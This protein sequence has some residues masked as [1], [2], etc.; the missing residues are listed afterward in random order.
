[1]SGAPSPRE[2]LDALPVG[3][4]S[5]LLRAVRRV[6]DD[7]P[8]S[9]LP[10]PLRPFAGWHPERLRDPRARAAVARALEDPDL[11]DRLLATLGAQ[12]EADEDTGWLAARRGHDGAAAV[13]AAAG[14][15]ADLATLAAAHAAPAA[16]VAREGG[17]D[18]SPTREDA[19]G[20]AGDGDDATG[21]DAGA[22]GGDHAAGDDEGA[23]EDAAAALR[24]ERDAVQRRAEAET[25][26]ASRLEEGLTRAEER[27]AALAEERDAL[28]RELTDLQRQHRRRVARLRERVRE[29][30][31][32]RQGV[33]AQRAWLVDEVE[34]LLGRLRATGEGR[35]PREAGTPHDGE[36]SEGSQA[37]TLP[38]AVP[39]AKAGRP[40]TL[41]QGLSREHA[42][43]VRAL[44]RAPGLRC[45]LDGYNLTKH[46]DG[47]P[48]ADLAT[49]RRWLVALAGGVAA[50]FGPRIVVVF[51]G[52]DAA[53]SPE[54]SPRD[55]LVVFSDAAETADD[56]IVDLVG[57]LD[58]DEP[59][60]VVTS[61]RELTE[62]LAPARVDVVTTPAFL[63][64][65]D[66]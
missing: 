48:M 8:R 4:W 26:R 5:P 63:A 1:M 25:A 38:R 3:L 50:R 32:A 56:R 58:A 54:A 16:S 45:V 17:P 39:P 43:G 57:A 52:A 21:E 31:G 34:G 23:G 51:D 19:D 60:L 55:V 15:W 41:P 24:E 37:A 44:L 65:V 53:P 66:A 42:D 9:T 14:R 2:A 6:T 30:E 28:R 49:Q 7:T 46:P 12:D 27:L 13:L 20:A 10:R 62:R 36:E 22:G 11:G 59:A 33:E 47:Q 40:C 61:D 64:A 29:A 35:A 18:G